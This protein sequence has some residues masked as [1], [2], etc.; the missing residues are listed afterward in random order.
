MSY[1]TN[2][3]P[4]VVTVI[5]RAIGYLMSGLL[6]FSAIVLIGLQ[7]YSW[8]KCG[9]W[10]PI[11]LLVVLPDINSTGWVGLDRMIAWV[12]DTPLFLALAI[13]AILT[14]TITEAICDGA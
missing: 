9:T 5:V 4:G 1:E 11:P 10:T 2:F 14:I 3:Y 6:G 12:I 7:C 13:S 8:L